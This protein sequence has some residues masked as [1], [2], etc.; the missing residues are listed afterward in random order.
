MAKPEWGRKHLCGSCGTK[1]Y[2]LRR[3][4]ATCP[5]CGAQAESDSAPRASRRS[6]GGAPKAA[7]A[8]VPYEAEAEAEVAADT[9]EE[10][11]EAE[12]EDEEE[13]EYGEAIEDAS[14][15]S[16]DQDLAE[17]V[18]EEDEET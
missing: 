14:E 11:A 6:R 16:E 13:E 9:E 8:A 7:A 17:V 3:V 12:A 10:T 1:F 15:L 4:P 2:D 18:T 5:S